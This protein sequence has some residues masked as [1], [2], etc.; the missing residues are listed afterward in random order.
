MTLAARERVAIE[1]KNVNHDT[2]QGKTDCPAK[3]PTGRPYEAP[4]GAVSRVQVTSLRAPTPRPRDTT[5]NARLR[6]HAESTQP[7]NRSAGGC[8]FQ[9]RQAVDTQIGVQLLD[10]LEAQTGHIKKFQ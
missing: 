1:S 9:R 3:P 2:L 4:A 5:D 6:L 8:V 7:A 10:F